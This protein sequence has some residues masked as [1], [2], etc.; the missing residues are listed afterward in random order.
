MDDLRFSIEWWTEFL[1]KD[2]SQKSSPVYWLQ[3]DLEKINAEIT[4]QEKL[5]KQALWGQEPVLKRL[6]ALQEKRLAIVSAINLE[7]KDRTAKRRQS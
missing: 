5:A 6:E 3:K 2:R 7:H 4:Q 1:D